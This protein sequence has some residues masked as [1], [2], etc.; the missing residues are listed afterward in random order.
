MDEKQIESVA[1]DKTSFEMG[2]DVYQSKEKVKFPVQVRT[3]KGELVE[4]QVSANVIKLRGVSFL[5]GEETLVDC[6]AKVHFG[7]RRMMF[8]ECNDGVELLRGSHL[9]MRLE[10]LENEFEQ[11]LKRKSLVMMSRVTKKSRSTGQGY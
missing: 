6:R 7:R 11:A 8:G 4:R 9:G 3:E 5:C 2:T 10:M 1:D